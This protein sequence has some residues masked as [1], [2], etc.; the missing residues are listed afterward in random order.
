M[1]TKVRR[2]Q[3]P[4]HLAASTRSVDVYSNGQAGYVAGAVLKRGTVQFDEHTSKEGIILGL[5]AKS[6]H[7]WHPSVRR[8]A[9]RLVAIR[10]IVEMA[11]TGEDHDVV[12]EALGILGASAEEIFVA[13]LGE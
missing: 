3:N 13:M 11:D 6:K 1:V 2:E 10:A 5:L 7:L 12:A 4:F 8:E 9:A